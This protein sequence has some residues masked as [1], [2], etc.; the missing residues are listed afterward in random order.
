[1][2]DVPAPI[3]ASTRFNSRSSAGITA[4]SAAIGSR[5]RLETSRPAPSITAYRLSTTSLGRKV[6]TTSASSSWPLWPFRVVR[7]YRSSW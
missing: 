5:V 3:S 1:M 2:S 4:F 7:G 6:A